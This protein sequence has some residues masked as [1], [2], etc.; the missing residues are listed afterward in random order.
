MIDIG[1][2][3]CIKYHNRIED[4]RHQLHNT[5]E[6]LSENYWIVNLLEHF[7][8]PEKFERDFRH[9]YGCQYLIISHLILDHFVVILNT[10]DHYG[11]S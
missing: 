6:K 5:E 4:N 2:E 7:D 8:R 11:H 9:D 10:S 3:I 1:E